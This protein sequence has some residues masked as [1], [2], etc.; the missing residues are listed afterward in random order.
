MP[1]QHPLEHRGRGLGLELE[2]HAAADN[3]AVVL[4]HGEQE[5]GGE[6]LALEVIARLRADGSVYLAQLEAAHRPLQAQHT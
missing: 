4:H 5:A 3:A 1:A 6:L 2:V